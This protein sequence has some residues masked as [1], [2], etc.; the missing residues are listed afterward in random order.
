MNLPGVLQIL[1]TLVVL[2]ALAFGCLVWSFIHNDFSVRMVAAH[3]N[4]ALPVYYR[5]AASWGN[6]EGSL[7]LWVLVLALWSLSVAA[8]SR[9]LPQSFASRVQGVLGLVSVGTILFS[10]A[11]SNPFA[12]L[13]PG[14]PDGMDLNPVLQDFALTIHPPMLYVGYVGFS[15]AFAFAIAALFMHTSVQVIAAAWHPW[16]G[17]QQVRDTAVQGHR[18]PS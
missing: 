7:L 12:R 6:H 15:V 10:L 9:N 14:P 2:L 11:T 4:S 5:V 3:S 18:G 16:R 17:A 13:Q 1:V 8:F